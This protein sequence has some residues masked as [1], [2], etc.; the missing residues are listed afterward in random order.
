M[1][2]VKVDGK[3]NY[4]N[5]F[6]NSTNISS[7]VIH[8]STLGFWGGCGSAVNLPSNLRLLATDVLKRIQGASNHQ[9]WSINLA[10]YN[11]NLII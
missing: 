8:F 1:Q 3:I 10:G 4:W 9:T 7:T 2:S 6:I 5:K 11:S